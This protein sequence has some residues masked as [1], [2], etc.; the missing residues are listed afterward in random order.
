MSGALTIM[1]GWMNAALDGLV[2]QGL[3]RAALTSGLRGFENGE[4]TG[5]DTGQV[6]KG[7]LA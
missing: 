3:D 5:S 4:A 1:A 6:L 2:R 7:P